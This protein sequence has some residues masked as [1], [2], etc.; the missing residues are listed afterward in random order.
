MFRK[1]KKTSL[2]GCIGLGIVFASFTFHQERPSVLQT[3]QLS[4]EDGVSAVLEKLGKVN[5]NKVNNSIEGVSAQNGEKL[6]SIGF[7]VKQNGKG[8]TSKQSPYFTCNACH[9]TAKEFDDLSNLSSQNRLEYAEKNDLP[10]LQGSSFYGLVNRTTFYNDDYQKKYGSVST[11]EAAS[12]DI[13]EAIQLCA[14]QCS[15]GRSLADWEIESLLAYFWTLEL[16]IKDLNLTLAEKTSLENSLT[17]QEDLASSI[18]LLQS[19]YS[20]NS[21]AHFQEDRPFEPITEAMKK[22]VDGFKNGQ[23]IYER[24][25]LHCHEKRRYSFFGLDNSQFSF[26]NLINRSKK[27]GKGGLHKITRYGTSPL[28]GKKAYMP[29]YPIEKLSEQQLED[30]RIYIENRALGNHLDVVSK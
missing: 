23:L 14:T 3:I 10:F 15:Q 6:V 4:E 19:K 22:D 1:F 5:N 29:L 7:S 9:N 26:V 30:L 20:Q 28:A 27:G 18:N 17:K 24:S 13:R 16:K 2:L 25:C 12:T 8:K 21:P 11:I